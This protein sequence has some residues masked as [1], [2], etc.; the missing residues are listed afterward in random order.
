MNL[1]SYKYF[2]NFRGKKS[3]IIAISSFFDTNENDFHLLKLTNKR[4]KSIEN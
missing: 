2:E 1:I 4:F 3:P